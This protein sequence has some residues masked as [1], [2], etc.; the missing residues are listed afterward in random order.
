MPTISAVQNKK[1]TKYRAYVQRAG[2]PKAT[3]IFDTYEQAEA[4]AA[5]LD[6]RLKE[7]MGEDKT[8]LKFLAWGLD[9][10]LSTS[11][12]VT[13]GDVLDRAKNFSLEPLCG[14][15]FI[16]VNNRIDY[17]G[18]STNIL[19]RLGQHAKV[20]RRCDR[21]AYMLCAVSELDALEAFYIKKFKPRGNS[22]QFKTPRSGSTPKPPRKSRLGPFDRTGLPPSLWKKPAP[23]EASN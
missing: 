5:D 18:Q 13:E 22:I 12:G 3:R 10:D 17:V 2:Y 8:R 21:I 1:G 19:C 11:L 7:R 16:V 9:R 23:K 4:W 14:I 15:Y 6:R 20:G